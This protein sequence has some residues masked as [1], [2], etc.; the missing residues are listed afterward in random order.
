MFGAAKLECLLLVHAVVAVGVL[1]GGAG[2]D[3]YPISNCSA[4]DCQQAGVKV[5]ECQNDLL[6]VSFTGELLAVLLGAAQLAWASR[7]DCSLPLILDQDHQA[8]MTVERLS[9]Q[10]A[11]W[12]HVHSLPAS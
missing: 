8:Q 3:L 2:P 7:A 5:S 11:A 12:L 1:P 9:R 6:V 10:A 4:L